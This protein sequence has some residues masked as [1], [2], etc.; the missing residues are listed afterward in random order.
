M[1]KYN[2][3]RR[4]DLPRAHCGV[5]ALAARLR[6]GCGD[7]RD[8]ERSERSG[9]QRDRERERAGVCMAG[10]IKKLISPTLYT[11]RKGVRQPQTYT[12]PTYIHILSAS[13]SHAILWFARQKNCP[14]HSKNLK[15]F[16]R[17][18]SKWHT[19]PRPMAAVCAIP[20]GS[21]APTAPCA[22]APGPSCAMRTRLQ[23][24]AWWA[25]QPCHWNGRRDEAATA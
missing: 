10:E 2:T 7:G 23:P 19:R 6:F 8:R 24:G 3:Q 15:C 17:E 14:K 20:T 12:C 21:A 5:S 9:P 11:L 13:F 25:R 4:K 18:N 22:P 1:R 16:W